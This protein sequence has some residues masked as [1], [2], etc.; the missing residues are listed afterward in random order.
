VIDPVLLREEGSYVPDM[1]ASV[2]AEL[3]DGHNC[4][5]CTCWICC[6]GRDCWCWL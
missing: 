2:E 5:I 3:A 6:N 1:D 4:T